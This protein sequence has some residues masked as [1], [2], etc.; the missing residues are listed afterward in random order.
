MQTGRNGLH[1]LT[2]LSVL[3]LLHAICVS[4][5]ILQKQESSAF[6]YLH[7]YA[8][9]GAGSYLWFL[10]KFDSA[11]FAGVNVVLFCVQLLTLPRAPLDFLALARI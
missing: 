2:L 11:P 8:A 6:R 9:V 4:H 10:H 3:F 1:G 5:G 7:D